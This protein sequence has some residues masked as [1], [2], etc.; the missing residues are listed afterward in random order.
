L[1]T[2]SARRRWRSGCHCMRVRSIDR[3]GIS[4]IGMRPYPLLGRLCRGMVN[5]RLMYGFGR[6]LP[7]NRRLP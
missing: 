7:L 6:I 3:I 4:E 5:A 1:A 2:F